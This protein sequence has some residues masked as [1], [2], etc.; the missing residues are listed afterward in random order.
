MLE[1]GEEVE[2]IADVL[3]TPGALRSVFQPVT[4]LAT[5]ALVAVEALVRGPAGP[6]ERPDVLFA[7]AREAG[8]LAALDEACRATAFRGATTLGLVAPLTLFVNVEPEVLASAPLDA[9]LELA[10]QAPGEL[11]VV[12]EITERALALRPAD[13]LRTVER[14]RSFGWGVALD[15]VGADPLSLAF[16][17]LLRP[18][19]VKLDLRLVQERPGA[20]VAQIMNA[21]NAYAES[22]GAVLLAEGI[23]NERHLRL[24]EGLGAQLGQ[25]WLFGRPSTNPDVSGPIEELLLPGMTRP[26]RLDVSPFACLPAGTPLR[27]APK[28]LLVEVSKQLEREAL[29]QGES[30]VVVTTF[31]DVRHFTPATAVRYRALVD[32]AGFVCAMAVGL[33][34]EPVPG[35][36]GVPLNAR[37]ELSAE[38]DITVLGP[39]FSA[40]LLARDLGDGGPDAKRRF[41]YALSYNRDTVVNA[42]TALLSRVT[43]ADPSAPAPTAVRRRSYPD[44][45]ALPAE[46]RQHLLERALA[47][48]TSGVTIA[49]V[50]QPDHPL[51]Y[52]NSGF[53]SLTGISATDLLGR[54]CRHLQG[55]GTDRAALARI[56]AALKAGTECREVL[57][58][59]RGPE[60]EPWWNEIFLVPVH[61]ESGTPAWYVGVQS[62]VSDRVQAQQQLIREQVRAQG[63]L[64]QI[65]RLAYTDGLTGLANRHRLEES[66]EKALWD[67]RLGGNGLALLF[68]DLDGL[69]AVNDERGHRAGDELLKATA[70]RLAGRVRHT[71]LVARLGGDEFVVL[72][73]G[74]KA[75]TTAVEAQRIATHLAQAI[76]EPLRVG[77]LELSI[78]ASIGISLY[79]DDGE[80]FRSLLHRA[81]ERMY[82]NKKA[83]TSVHSGDPLR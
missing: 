8:C 10:S 69:K 75:T 73:P 37:D 24:A 68:L 79:P 14:I 59:F 49:D 47:A 67:A 13:L 63:Y 61:D 4:D 50:R 39:H 7:A 33:P 22:S 66:L 18:D 71:D 40:A 76:R 60:A 30:C 32:S 31:Q 48:T 26:A 72:L 12:L 54:N 55:P 81:D 36:R 16:M 11:R 56:R 78:T 42:T 41:Q 15:D 43:A 6:W 17:P 65:E 77:D 51:L 82:A 44:T 83:R 74:L 25:G 27:V 3:R 20:A 58:N 21:V 62:D 34:G 5:G 45:A 29:T 35:L 70:G 57:L 46:K 80:D 53:E 28:A 1:R 9:L 64:E 52:V 23:E 38:W 19:I 2:G